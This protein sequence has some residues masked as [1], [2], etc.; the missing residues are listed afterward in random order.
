MGRFN[1][2]NR[3]G[4]RA[5]GGRG[6]GFQRGRSNNRFNKTSTSQQKEL[7]YTPHVQGKLQSAT[8]ATVTEAVIHRIQRDNRKGMDVVKSL[9]NMKKV[10]LDTLRPVRKSSTEADEEARI[11]EQTQ[12]D[13]D[14]QEEIKRWL[15]RK[16]ALE[17]GLHQAYA[18]I[19]TNYCSK[20][21]EQRVE[22]HPDFKTKIEDDPIALLE[23]IK[24][25]M[26]DSIRAQY[27]FVS[28]TD[29]LSRLLTCRQYDNEQL[30]DYTKRFKQQR[31]VVKSYLG[32]SLL[33][34]FIEHSEEYRDE[35]DDAVKKTLKEDAF[36]RWM[37][38]LLIK[39]CD[40]TKY[41]TLTKTF[42]SQYSLGNDQY[43]K[44]IQA[45]IDALSN[46]KIDPKYWENKQRAKAQHRE[47]KST[48]PPSTGANFAQRDSSKLTCY[49]CG[50]KGHSSPNCPDKD[51][52]PRDQ[53][54]VNR[55]LNASQYHDDY[56][57]GD[58]SEDTDYSQSEDDRSISSSNRRS[59]RTNDRNTNRDRSRSRSTARTGFS[60]LQ[61]CAP[62]CI[63]IEHDQ[64]VT[65]ASNAAKS[66][67]DGLDDNTINL[68]SGST[69]L[70]AIKNE[71]LVDNLRVSERPLLMYTNAGNRTSPMEGDLDGFGTVSVNKDYM[72]NTVGVGPLI[73]AGWW[74][75][76]DSR[77]RDAFLANP[78]GDDGEPLVFDRTAI[79]LYGLTVSDSF[80][81]QV[82]DRKRKG[83]T[84]T[85]LSNLISTVEENKKG[86]T[87]RQLQDAKKARA[88]YHVLGCPSTENFK[89][90]LRQKIIRNC[91]I[92][93]EDVNNA[94]KIYGPDVGML[95]GK[96]TRPKPPLVKTDVVEIPPEILEQHGDLTF[97]TDLMFINGIPFLTGIDKSVRNRECHTLENRTSKE[98]YRAIDNVFRR[99]NNAGFNITD[100]HVDPEYKP[101]MDPVADDLGIN[102]NYTAKGEHVPEAE[103]NNRVIQERVRSTFHNLPYKAIPRIMIQHL[104]VESTH[105][106]N[107]FPAKG[108]VSPYYSPYVLMGGRDLD[109]YKDCAIPFGAYVQAYH[110]NQPTNTNVQRT[111]DAI[112][113][114]PLRN[115][116]GGH[117]LMDLK[118]GRRITR[119]HVVEVPITDLVIQAVEAMA[120]AQGIKTLKLQSKHGNRLYP[121][122][123]LAGV[124]YQDQ[125]HN[126]DDDENGE[127]YENI[128]E[129]DFDEELDDEE[130]YDRIDQEEIDE[131]LA[132][133]GQNVTRND[134]VDPAGNV[135]QEED[136]DEPD[137]EPEDEPQVERPRRSARQPERLTY[138]HSQLDEKRVTF[139]DQERYDLECEHNLGN[140]KSEDT[141][142]YKS[143]EAMIYARIISDINGKAT[144]KG[145]SFAQQ[146]LLQKGLKKFGEKGRAAT[147]K[148]LDQLHQRNCF[149]P[150]DVKS[151]SPAEKR[152]AQEALLFLTEKRDKTIKG[153]MVYNGKPTREW[154]SREDSASPTAALESIM[155]TAVVDAKE[156]RDVMTADIPNA[157]IQTDMPEVKEGQERVT[158]KITGVLVDLLVEVAP[159]VYADYVVFENGKKV[160]YV[161]VM[162]ALYGMLVASLLWYKKFKSDLQKD[163]FRFN[164]Y[165]PCVANKKVNGKRH[166]I[167][168]HVDDLMCSHVDPKVNDRFEKWLNA[169]Y[170]GYGKV[171][172]TRGKV[173]DYLGM[174]FDF[175]EK[176]KVKIDMIDYMEAMVDD[177]SIK[178]KPNETAPSPAADDLFAEGEG[179]KL[180]KDSADEFHTFVAKGLFACKRARPDIHTAIAVLCTR[181]KEPNRDDWKKLVRLIKYINGTR[182]DKLVL[183]AD[184]LRILKWYVDSAFAVH[185]DFKSHTGGTMTFGT[186]AAQ[187]G[188]RKQKLNTRSSTE[189]EL[190]GA[191]DMS[192]MILWTKHFMEAQGYK[193]KKNI[194]YQDNKST[195]LLETNGKKSSSKR[196]RALNI[197][198]FFLTD[199][200]AKGNVQVEYCPTTEMV[201]DYMT[202]PLQGPQFKKL[203]AQIMGH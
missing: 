168:F 64:A 89:N 73:D 117:V 52:I 181:V 77:V 65:L 108:G 101:L 192:V 120:E 144:T 177:F 186:G 94:E 37:A 16:E 126:D 3:R 106:L 12:F 110:G 61:S 82:A 131:L 124:E 99:Y 107:Y 18:L 11:H 153:R 191:D 14:Y 198:Y 7:K 122:D 121:A 30:L 113:L 4:G 118:T 139:E 164:P 67:L 128:D 75:R 145:A 28:A 173:H 51:K 41:G 10:D 23:V 5:T 92:T 34:H 182:K 200:I 143:S 49:C 135:E 22:A 55:V 185:P 154:L 1:N 46:H 199:Q 57:S 193:I 71:N 150:L 114:G 58:E 161:Q 35:T 157:F 169:M 83:G 32:T 76:M 45:A 146:Y 90:I 190:V 111:L 96:T 53:W 159:E 170:G 151:L 74:I 6:R 165:D 103:R 127:E 36:D 47:E 184:D 84:K 119:H 79:G 148:E 134:E 130:A 97:C 42:V 29:A 167:R 60:S 95:K 123:W 149:S 54:Y 24:T 69:M 66:K 80:L 27:P 188:S 26:H 62:V 160:L 125:N 196:T 152:K 197:R 15:D 8:Y 93:I 19:V 163:G 171:K 31:D 202:K 155:L 105:Q 174:T 39:N 38:Y 98:L 43:P 50:K 162:K 87:Q 156:G 104:A 147:T 100:M 70:G 178:F 138:S 56:D 21:M 102:M 201:A 2:N 78:P 68:D 72:A 25:L 176:G 189:S 183:S 179:N 137:P 13:M 172:A 175:S 91:P 85:H 129:D 9:K 142:E 141:T 115:K 48:P 40:Q 140:P 194:L 44:T 180:D 88:L 195:I 63:P 81:K 136:N 17:Q 166:T 20:T 133:P 112:Y 109:Y 132:E 33:D 203:K 158:M 86:F 187:T 59:G 116:Q